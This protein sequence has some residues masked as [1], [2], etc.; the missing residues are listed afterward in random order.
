MST[1]QHIFTLIVFI[2][3]IRPP[4]TAHAEPEG[5][6]ESGA[7]RAERIG[8]RPKPKGQRTPPQLS[9]HFSTIPTSMHFY[10]LFKIIWVKN[11]VIIVPFTLLSGY[12]PPHQ[13]FWPKRA[14][15][16]SPINTSCPPFT[17]SV[18]FHITCSSKKVYDDQILK[19]F[20]ND[21]MKICR[22]HIS[23][24]MMYN[25]YQMTMFRVCNISSKNADFKSPT[26]SWD[27]L[28]TPINDSVI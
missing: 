23:Y 15:H 26:K 13:Q 9:I 25:P 8:N 4:K 5:R 18:I 10:R 6:G 2:V 21:F 11:S 7:Q 22:F 12:C 16:T 27:C 3:P 19:T 14:D 20:Q 1:A 17:N 24:L 28:S